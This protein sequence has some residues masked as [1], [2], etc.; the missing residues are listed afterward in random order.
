MAALAIALP[1]F[2]FAPRLYGWIVQERLR[3]LYRRLRV[4]EKALQ[5]QL[6]KKQMEA[7][8]IEIVDIDR[9]ADSISM[10]NSDLY[11]ILRHHLDRARS[12]LAEV[13]VA[14]N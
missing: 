1:V 14:R 10:R 6:T 5:A 3:K 12:H 4:V 9:A 13:I 8:Q 2:S 7:L 11:F